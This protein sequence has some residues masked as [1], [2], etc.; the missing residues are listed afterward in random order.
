MESLLD[1]VPIDQEKAWAGKCRT[2]HDRLS[3]SFHELDSAFVAALGTSASWSDSAKSD[4]AAEEAIKALFQEVESVGRRIRISQAERLA[5]LTAS[6]TEAVR[7]VSSAIKN[8]SK[9]GAGGS[10]ANSAFS[11]LEAM[12][13]S[14]SSIIPSMA[15][16]DRVLSDLSQRVADAKT[17]AMQ[18]M[19]TRLRQISIAQSAIARASS[20]VT[21]LRSALSQQKH[22]MEH[23]EHVVE[24]PRAYN[25]FLSEIRR[26]RAYCI[27]FRSNATALLERLELMRADEVKLRE[28]FLRG[29]GRHLMPAFYEIFAPTLATSPPMFSPPLPDMA[30]LEILPD[31]GDAPALGMSSIDSR[32]TDGRNDE[33][34]AS[35]TS[36]ITD[37]PSIHHL[38]SS[39]ERHVMVTSTSKNPSLIVSA[40]EASGNDVIMQTVCQEDTPTHR[41]QDNADCATLLYENAV[42]RQALE[43]AGCEPPP[44]YIDNEAVPK[45]QSSEQNSK[46]SSMESELTAMKL[47]LK[48]VRNEADQL[49]MAQAEKC[50]NVQQQKECDKISHTSFEVGDVGLFMP[51]GRSQGGKRVYLAFHSGCPHRY[52]SPDCISGTPDFVLGRIVYQEETIAGVIDSDSNPFGLHAGTK[53]WVLTVETLKRG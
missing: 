44:T 17:N 53:Y 30:E 28:R 4:F 40:V 18:R 8:E 46:L 51:T 45:I 22:D 13:Q 20:S 52:L 49:R 42:L 35:S 41:N 9:E 32:N 27:A 2:A 29:P 48:K 25:D 26:R 43:H 5:T 10:G 15:S 36:T 11:E 1:A 12:S 37:C 39:K 33:R 50:I 7:I 31:V 3:T 14:T 16:D 47:E 23:L 19:K 24:L 34:E 38:P 6:H 21:V